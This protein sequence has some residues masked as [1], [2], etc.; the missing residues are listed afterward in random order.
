M[1]N[2]D[3]AAALQKAQEKRFK[4]LETTADQIEAELCRIAF[5][6]IAAYA[7]LGPNG[8]VKFTDWSKLPE[9]ASRVISEL[10]QELS[11]SARL[12][13]AKAKTRFKLHD[14][15]S[16]L[17]LLAQRHGMLVERH[18][19]SGP[20]G[21][22]IEVEHVGLDETSALAE[23]AAKATPNAVPLRRTGTNG[24]A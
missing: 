21:K 3:I 5:A 7:E 15:I 1:T 14:K 20:G 23:E 12:G 2:V 8:S 18:E 13:T 4:R 10:T 19:H 9:G 6:D 11:G 24:K 17:R 16:A 22:P